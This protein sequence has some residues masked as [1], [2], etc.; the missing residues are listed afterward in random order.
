MSQTVDTEVRPFL[1]STRLPLPSTPLSPSVSLSLYLSPCLSICHFRSVSLSINSLLGSVEPVLET[2]SDLTCL[3]FRPRQRPQSPF[4]SYQSGLKPVSK[5][6]GRYCPYSSVKPCQMAVILNAPRNNYLIIL[7]IKNGTSVDCDLPRSLC[8][9]VTL[10]LAFISLAQCISYF[11]KRIRTLATIFRFSEESQYLGFIMIVIM[12]LKHGLF[13]EN[14]IRMISI[15]D[16]N[17][18]LCNSCRNSYQILT[19]SIHSNLTLS[20]IAG[21]CH[22]YAALA[23]CYIIIA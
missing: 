8:K 20:I 5:S 9:A 22:Q 10:T 1:Q 11:S 17:Q 23:D 14:E 12:L 3:K 19:V 16:K 13:P 21:I 6:S 18:Y 4:S 7:I 2:W 15:P